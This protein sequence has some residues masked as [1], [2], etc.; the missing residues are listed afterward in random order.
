MCGQHR[1]SKGCADRCGTKCNKTSSMVLCGKDSRGMSS[2]F[3]LCEVQSISE[4]CSE[5][6]VILVANISYVKGYTCLALHMFL[7]QRR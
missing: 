3:S 2:L 4:E 6:S 1:V 7:G 5:A